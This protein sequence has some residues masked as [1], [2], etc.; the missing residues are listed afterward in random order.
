[1]KIIAADAGFEMQIRL[2][3]TR[4]ASIG[5]IGFEGLENIR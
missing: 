1:M 5:C 4:Q 3:L 2:S